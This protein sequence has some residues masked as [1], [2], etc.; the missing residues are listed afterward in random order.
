MRI[1]SPDYPADVSADAALALGIH[2]GLLDNQ[3]N[4]RPAT[5]QEI[6]NFCFGPLKQIYDDFVKQRAIAANPPQ[7]TPLDV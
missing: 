4:T 1:Q 6:K 5:A 3:R 7:Y 2:L